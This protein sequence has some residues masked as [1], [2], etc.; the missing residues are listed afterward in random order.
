MVPNWFVY[1]GLFGLAIIAVVVT[2][3]TGKRWEKNGEGK[4]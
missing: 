2:Y 3:V 1:L 4:K